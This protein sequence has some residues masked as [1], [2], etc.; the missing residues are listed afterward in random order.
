MNLTVFG[1]LNRA[2]L[3]GDETC[4]EGGYRGVR[5]AKWGEVYR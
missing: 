3:F 5:V 4:F 2:L 1:S